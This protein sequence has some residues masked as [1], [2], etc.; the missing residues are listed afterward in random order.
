[1]LRR[2]QMILRYYVNCSSSFPW[3]P[4]EV[5]EMSLNCSD[6]WF[7]NLWGLIWWTE[8][9]LHMKIRVYI[10]AFH[11]AKAFLIFTNRGAHVF[12][13]N[14]SKNKG[15]QRYLISKDP[16]NWR[17]WDCFLNRRI[18]TN[19]EKSALEKLGLKSINCEAES[20]GVL[21]I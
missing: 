8:L 14:L 10:L 3:I 17:L 19:K 18:S 5:V 13:L 6:T 7:R 11:P 20:S 1:M 2:E 16:I 4:K 21:L 12:A 9:Y 15:R